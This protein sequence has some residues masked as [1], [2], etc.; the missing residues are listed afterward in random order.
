VTPKSRKRLVGWSAENHQGDPPSGEI[1]LIRNALI[2]GDQDIETTGF[3]SLQNEP[4][5]QS[6]Q[7]GEAS[8]LAVVA[9][10]QRPQALVDA[11]ID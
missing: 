9:R 4:I 5:F 11:L 10:E 2:D 8:R 1:L 3:G 6:R 7:I